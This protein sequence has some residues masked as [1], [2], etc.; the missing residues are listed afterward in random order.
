MVNLQLFRKVKLSPGIN[1][2]RNHNQKRILALLRLFL[3][4]LGIALYLLFNNTPDKNLLITLIIVGIYSTILYFSTHLQCFFIRNT[5]FVLGL[6]EIAIFA[7]CYFSGGLYSP[8]LPVFLFPVLA[9]AINPSYLKLFVA[10]LLSIVIIFLLGI[11]TEFNSTIFAYV[12]LY[13]V[14]SGFLVNV[15]VYNDY[16]L[17]SDYA[18]KDGLTGLYTHQYFFDHLNII[19]TDN[20][21]QGHF[22]LIMIDL[23]E[24]KKLNDDLGHL[25]GDRV[26]KEVAIAIKENVRESDIVARYGGDEFALILPGVG[27]TLCQSI[28]ERLR[29]AIIDLGY[30]TAVSI[31]SALYPDEETDI[32]KLVYLADKR[33]YE[34]KSRSKNI[35][36]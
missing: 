2:K 27:Y 13:I 21:D 17:L 11:M 25:E 35:E 34:Q 18:A 15:L 7:V 3:S 23:D 33:M 5:L 16:K 14:L 6:D 24:F 30:F 19:M 10:M 20:H 12:S 36:K 4:Y 9:Y 8:F 29:R 32:Y 31:G 28:V 1:Y 22:S 26:L